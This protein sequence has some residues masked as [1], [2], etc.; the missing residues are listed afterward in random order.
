ML[1][2]CLCRGS[3]SKV[4]SCCRMEEIALC[5]SWRNLLELLADC[6]EGSPIAPLYCAGTECGP[7]IMKI[8]L[9]AHGR[10]PFPFR[11]LHT[12][13][14]MKRDAE[15]VMSECEIRC[16]FHGLLQCSD[17]VVEKPPLNLNLSLKKECL[18]VSRGVVQHFGNER[19]C[20]VKPMIE[21][22]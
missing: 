22:Q 14:P 7:G 12:P 20:F 2:V 9:Q 6:L 5:G 18:R 4:E 1:Q 11:L 15:L 3:V 17:T 19:G 8:R 10:L 16:E 13:L 21:D